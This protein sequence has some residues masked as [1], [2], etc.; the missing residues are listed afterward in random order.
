MPYVHLANGDVK[1]L[2]PEEMDEQFGDNPPIVFRDGNTESAIIGVYP[3]DVEI[4]S[5]TTPNEPTKPETAAQRTESTT[6][7]GRKGTK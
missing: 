5:D 3:D 6:D 7:F 2:S 4:E 1:K